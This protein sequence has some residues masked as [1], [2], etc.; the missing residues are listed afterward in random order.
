MVARGGDPE[1]PPD[2]RVPA[3]DRPPGATLRITAAEQL[4]H[5][6]WELL[7]RDG[8]YLTVAGHAPVL[9]VRAVGTNTTLTGSVARGN[10]PLRVLFMA[11]SPEGVEPVLNFEAE[12]AAILSA[13]VRT[14]AELVVEESGTLDGLPSLSLEYGAGYFDVLHLSGHAEIGKDGQLG[15]WWRG[16]G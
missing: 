6:P 9:P 11:T 10:S 16:S 5:L 3:P 4:R 12:E 2:G 1:A 14:G 7:A 15:S 8:S 13:T